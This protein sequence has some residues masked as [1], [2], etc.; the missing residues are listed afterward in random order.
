MDLSII[1][2]LLASGVRTGTSI[3]LATLG[4]V[5]AE[6]AGVLNLGVEG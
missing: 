3:L 6:R 5:V 1:I 4:E 2:T